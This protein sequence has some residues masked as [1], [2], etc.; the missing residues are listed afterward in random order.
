MAKAISPTMDVMLSKP[1]FTSHQ[2][3]NI[4]V[5][6]RR[7]VP[8]LENYCLFDPSKD[9]VSE[10]K[11]QHQHPDD[12]AVD[13]NEELIEEIIYDDRLDFD[14]EVDLP[15]CNDDVLKMF[16]AIY[17]ANEV[18]SSVTSS[19]SGSNETSLGT[20]TS[21][22]TSGDLMQSSIIDI[23]SSNNNTYCSTPTRSILKKPSAFDTPDNT[24]SALIYENDIS[25][26]ASC[27][28]S[29]LQIHSLNS[30][31]SRG[32]SE[33]NY[34]VLQSDIDRFARTGARPKSKYSDLD[35][36]FLSPLSPTTKDSVDE[37]ADH[38]ELVE[39]VA[40]PEE[41]KEYIQVGNNN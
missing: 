32:S 27:S 22:D 23:S 20:S 19:T 26:R 13:D 10:K 39:Q 12:V 41:I 11:S 36:G 4:P 17:E 9:F 25:L 15:I 7:G 33:P 35:S 2:F 28:S 8:H 31:V 38:N 14:E 37:G 29:Q 16:G 34:V 21:T 5:R 18:S 40:G 24:P 6:P 3:Q 1:E 30:V